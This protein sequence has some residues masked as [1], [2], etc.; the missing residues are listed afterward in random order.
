MN[1]MPSLM[2][3]Y[4][5]SSFPLSDHLMSLLFIVQSDLS[6]NQRERLVTTLLMLFVFILEMGNEQIHH[7]AHAHPV[8]APLVDKV[9]TELL[10][11]GIISLLLFTLTS[12][13]HEDSQ[14]EAHGHQ[15][16]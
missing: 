4:H 6:E 2:Q 8:A 11:L 1:S 10:N 5:E 3:V 16:R 14:E 9:Y 12:G 15:G 7:W 13:H